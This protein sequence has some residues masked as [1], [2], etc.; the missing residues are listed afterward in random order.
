M[1]G[2]FTDLLLQSSDP[3]KA[4]SND[5]VVKALARHNSDLRK[6]PLDD[7]DISTN[8]E[9]VIDNVIRRRLGVKT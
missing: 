9:E 6:Q 3:P 2:V 8:P 7:I 4:L 5:V 1:H